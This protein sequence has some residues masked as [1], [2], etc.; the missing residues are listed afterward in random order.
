MHDPLKGKIIFITG[1]VR[2]IGAATARLAK[3]YGA[4]VALRCAAPPFRS[5]ES[6]YVKL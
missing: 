1:S 2:G 3:S 5:E 6:D 4:T